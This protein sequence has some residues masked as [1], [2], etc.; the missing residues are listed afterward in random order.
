[1]LP[2]VSIIIP[3]FNHGEYL[4]DALDNLKPDNAFYEVIIV[5]DGSTDEQTI[6]VIES[7]KAKN[8]IVVGQENMGLSAARNT[9]ISVS[10]GDF[11]M[12]LDADNT[13]DLT[14]MEKAASILESDPTLAVVYSD[15]EL[16]G[17]QT[18]KR[19]VG[20]FNLQ[21]LMISNYIDACAMIRKSVFD[22]LGG[23]DSQMKGGWED[24]ELWLRIAFSGRRFHYIPETGFRYRVYPGSMS[25]I[26]G[27]NYENRNKLTAYLHE[28]YPSKMGHQYIT[29]FVVKRF[30]QRPVFFIA[31]MS[32]IAWFNKYYQKLLNKNKIIE[33]I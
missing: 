12:P 32:I 27:R 33:G 19:S 5:N 31:K 16:F 28:K 7:C 3:C 18:G 4:Q 1:M 26:I 30:K 10:K 20:E 8:Y 9:G 29:D 23:Y 25:N 11:I 24:W 21:R 15:M 22:E 17:S 6:K 2:K 13:L 14:F